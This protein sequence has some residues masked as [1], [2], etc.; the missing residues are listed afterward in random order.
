[1]VGLGLVE[2]VG[3]GRLVLVG[4]WVL[5]SRE[6]DEHTSMVPHFFFSYTLTS[7]VIP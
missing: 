1:M 5:V 4:V 6:D 7:F 3:L 2:E